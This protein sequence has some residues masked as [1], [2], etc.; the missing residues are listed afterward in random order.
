MSPLEHLQSI[1]NE[2]YISEDGDEYKVGL[3]PGLPDQQIDQLA[4][5]LPNGRISPDIRELLRF[6]SGF[7]F[8]GLDDVTFDGVGMFGFENIFPYSIQLAGDGFGNFWILDVANDGKWSSVFYVCHDPAVVVRHSNDLG[9]FIK[10]IDE[11][12][13]KGKDS[14]L[15]IIHEST[16][17]DIWKMNDGFID[18][19]NARKSSGR[20]LSEFAL[21]L[22]DH[23]T[24]VDL[25]NKPNR[26]GFAWGKFGPNIDKA[27][28]HQTEL[29]WGFEKGG[30]QSKPDKADHQNKKGILSRLFG[31]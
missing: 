9:E 8:Y 6:A 13:K 23:F 4:K 25:R 24:V 28:R 3:K 29:I 20:T 17:M 21:G 19:G 10:H 27:V 31:R 14:N 1:L 16:V 7:E 30:K 26:T 11:Y 18:I 5:A 15:D 12:G 2:T 22:P